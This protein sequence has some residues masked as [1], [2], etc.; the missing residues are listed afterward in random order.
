[1][2]VKNIFEVATR[3]K[4]RFIGYKGSIGVEQLWDVNLEG[5]N[6]IFQ[7]LNEEL[8]K[9]Q[10]ESLLDEK[11]KETEELETKIA[12]IRHIVAVKQAEQNARVDEKVRK[13]ELREIEQQIAEK[14]KEEAK[15]LTLE[16]LEAKRAALLGTENK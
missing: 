6:T 2:T 4:F 8:K 10:Q 3:K 12:I 9:G 13:E 11:T 15:K 16:E 7:G 14:K 5:L 1:M